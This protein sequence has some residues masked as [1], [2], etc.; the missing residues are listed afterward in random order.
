MKQ[1]NRNYKYVGEI[2]TQPTQ[3]VEGQV[4]SIA[5]MLKRIQNGMMP[6]HNGLEYTGED[7]PLQF[8]DLTD[9]DNARSELNEY[10][11]RIARK[12]ANKEKEAQGGASD[13]AHMREPADES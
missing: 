8:K 4:Q 1:H 7:D 11:Q 9:L 12:N 5:V 6:N 3:T 13:G 2:F 10:Q